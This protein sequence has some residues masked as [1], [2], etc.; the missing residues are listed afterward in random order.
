MLVSACWYRPVGMGSDTNKDTNKSV[1][2]KRTKMD[3][4]E[5]LRTYK[6]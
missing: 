6:D 3:A 4:R 5:R 1:G 2:F